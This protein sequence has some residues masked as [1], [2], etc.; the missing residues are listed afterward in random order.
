LLNFE[1]SKAERINIKEVIKQ[2]KEFQQ[3]EIS[4]EKSR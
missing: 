1:K 3:E 4:K 2:I